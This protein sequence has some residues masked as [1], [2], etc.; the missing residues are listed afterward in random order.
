MW[1]LIIDDTRRQSIDKIDNR[2]KS[3]IPKFEWHGCMGEKREANFDN[4]SMFLFRGSILLVSMRIGNKVLN[5]YLCEER[6]KSLLLP[7]PIR[8]ESQ[9]L[10]IKLTFNKLLE[11]TKAL[12]HLRFFP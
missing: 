10:F 7:S 1:S 5:P 11:I 2:N 6:I 4:V 12:E 9:D 3:L 8:L